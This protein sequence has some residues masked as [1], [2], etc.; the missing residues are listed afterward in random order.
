[1]AVPKKRTSKTRQLKRR[2]QISLK[3]P[4]LTK[5]PKCGK[6]ILPHTVCQ[7][8]GYYKGKIVLEVLEKL[9]KKERKKREKEIAARE[10]EANPKIET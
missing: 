5:C 9:D 8:C 7:Y 2:A 4:T 6:D 1:M 10:K 3:L